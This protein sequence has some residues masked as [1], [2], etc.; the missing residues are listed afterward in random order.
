M[1]LVVGQKST[2]CRDQAPTLSIRY[3]SERPETAA[4]SSPTI[5]HHEMASNRGPVGS[6]SRGRIGVYGL[7]V[8]NNVRSQLV[9]KT[10]L[11]GILPTQKDRLEWDH[12]FVKNVDLDCSRLWLSSFKYYTRGRLHRLPGR[13]HSR[14]DKDDN[15][16]EVQLHA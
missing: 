10:F 14:R 1:V 3:R 4:L 9:L 8:D 7:R 16:K 15:A 13:V 11:A 5:R 2:V 12:Y 6:P